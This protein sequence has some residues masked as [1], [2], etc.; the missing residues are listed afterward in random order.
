MARAF[1][2]SAGSSVVSSY[3]SCLISSWSFFLMCSGIH[4]PVAGRKWL[5]PQNLIVLKL[6]Y[7]GA[8][9]RGSKGAREQ[10]S[11]ETLRLS[12]ASM[13]LAARRARE[14]GNRGGRRVC[15]LQVARSLAPLLPCSLLSR[16][17]CRIR[18][19]ATWSTTLRCFCRAWPA[20]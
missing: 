5:R 1:L 8:R 19:A 2:I 3:S 14:Q 12:P 4:D 15:E 9:E 17:D 13:P 7:K 16:N 20:W 18:V 10:G 11:K 6:H